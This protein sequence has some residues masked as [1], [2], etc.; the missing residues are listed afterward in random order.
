MGFPTQFHVYR[1][2]KSV[3]G[4]LREQLQRRGIDGPSA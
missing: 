2:L 4:D 1:R 3:L